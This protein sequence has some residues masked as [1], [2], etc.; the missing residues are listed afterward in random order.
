MDLDVDSSS[1]APMS[2]WVL[3]LVLVSGEP[4]SQATPHTPIIKTCTRYTGVHRYV[5]VHKCGT[6]ACVSMPMIIREEISPCLGGPSTVT[7]SRESLGV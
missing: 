3:R 6:G 5:H 2:D 1:Q 4:C 7:E